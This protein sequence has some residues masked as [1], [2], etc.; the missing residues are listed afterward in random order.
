MPKTFIYGAGDLNQKYIGHKD[1]NVQTKGERYHGRMDTAHE[2]IYTAVRERYHSQYTKKYDLEIK[3]IQ[4]LICRFKGNKPYKTKLNQ[5]N[6]TLLKGQGLEKLQ[7]QTLTVEQKVSV[8]SLASSELQKKKKEILEETEIHSKRLGE[9]SVN[10][11]LAEIVLIVTTQNNLGQK[12]KTLPISFPLSVIKDQHAPILS[13]FNYKSLSDDKAIFKKECQTYQD[14]AID[15]L[16]KA[17]LALENKT[18]QLNYETCD[19]AYFPQVAYHSEKFLFYH[20]MNGGLQHLTSLFPSKGVIPTAIAS[21]D[22]MEIRIHSTRDICHTCEFLS[23]GAI[24]ELKECFNELLKQN[25]FP[26]LSDAFKISLNM[27]YQISDRSGKTQENSMNI[28]TLN[29]NRLAKVQEFIQNF[30]AH[31]YTVFE[32]GGES[33]HSSAITQ[34]TAHLEAMKEIQEQHKKVETFLEKRAAKTILKYWQ[35]CK[36]TKENHKEIDKTLAERPV[37]QAKM[38]GG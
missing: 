21:I 37:S 5:L 31:R 19:A 1:K 22:A 6:K 30:S 7:D 4:D 17:H 33:D 38:G 11:A 23:I 13:I 28:E 9:D 34:R 26:E 20:L 15:V 8:L 2:Q 36:K 12:V 24:A 27:S 29:A 18:A 10:F 14:K 32:S 3:K 25:K 16:N 35:A